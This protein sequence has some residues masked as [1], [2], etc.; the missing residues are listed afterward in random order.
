MIPDVASYLM[1]FLDDKTLSGLVRSCRSMYMTCSKE[2]DRR[3]DTCTV[4][5]A[6]ATSC[7]YAISHLNIQHV[8][9]MYISP[10]IIVYLNKL[11]IPLYSPLMRYAAEHGFLDMAIALHENGCLWS[12]DAYFEAARNGHLHVLSYL[13]STGLH[14]LHP[15]MTQDAAK[16][17]HL[18]IL[19][20]IHSHGCD[21]DPL[22]CSHAAMGGHLYVLIYLANNGAVLNERVCSSAAYNG[23][24]YVLSVA[25]NM[26]APWDKW[27]IAEASINGHLHVIKYA[28]EHGCPWDATARVGACDTIVQYLDEHNCPCL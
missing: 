10:D 1:P 18:H 5:R 7:K 19:Q 4:P 12:P 28:H 13:H 3:L 17:G 20:Y 25:R 11:D 27:T 16:N 23:H 8:P 15:A 2:M 14:A 22:V 26:G 24:L 21:W 6:I 9:T